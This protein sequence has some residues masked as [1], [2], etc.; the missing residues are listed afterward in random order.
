MHLSVMVD[1]N[2]CILVYTL[3]PAHAC[4]ECCAKK[5]PLC[6]MLGFDHITFI[7][8]SKIQM[9]MD[10]KYMLGLLD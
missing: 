4:V 9:D 1:N 2:K 10:D 5:K 7:I 6:L 8:I 3:F